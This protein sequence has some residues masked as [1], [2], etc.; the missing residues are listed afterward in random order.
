MNEGELDFSKEMK[1]LD[2][3]EEEAWQTKKGERID[4]KRKK[5]PAQLDLPLPESSEVEN[6]REFR[7]NTFLEKT[8]DLEPTERR[9]RFRNEFL[10][11][12]LETKNQKKEGS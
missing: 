8:K 7:I 12:S 4:K 3:L 11:S 6:S 2:R 5:T 10:K 1:V 9:R